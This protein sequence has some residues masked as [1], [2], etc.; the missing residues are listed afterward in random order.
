MIPGVSRSPRTPHTKDV[1]KSRG[2]FAGILLT[3]FSARAASLVL[4]FLLPAPS[5]AR[6]AEHP[7]QLLPAALAGEIGTLAALG[8][9]AAAVSWAS[10]RAGLLV[11]AGGGSFLLVVSQLDLE[12]VR[13]TGEHLNPYW[14]GAYNL[15]AHRRLLK[16]VALG[17]TLALVVAVLL[18]AVPAAVVIA[19]ARRRGPEHV[20][21]TAAAALAALSCAALASESRLAPSRLA[22]RR[23]RPALV[24][25]VSESVAAIGD[26]PSPREVR[27]GIATLHRFLNRPP[28]WF[29]EAGYPVWH[30]AP[31]E[32]A[33][34]A[35]FRA[36]PADGKPD[37]LLVVLESA[38]GW[39]TDV[40]RP[41]AAAR[42]PELHRLWKERG[43]AF[44][45]CIATGYPSIEGRGGIL[46]GIAGHPSGILLY[47]ARDLRVLS[48]GEILARAGYVREL[49]AATSPAFEKMEYWYARWFDAVRY[50]PADTTDEDLARRAVERLEA[51]REAPLFLTLFTIATHPPL[52]RPPGADPKT[53][54]ER[55]LAALGYTDRA[56]GRIFESLRRTPRG[57]NTVVIVVGDHATANPWQAI[58][59]PRL[60]TPNAGENWTTLLV[61]GPGLPAGSVR[62]DLTSQL[63]VGPTLLGLLGLDVSNHF[64]GRDLFEKPAPLP[65]GVFALRFHGL[66]AW[67]GPLLLQARLDD[68]SFAQA[69]RWEPYE[70]EPDPENGD[71]HHGVKQ[72]LSREVQARIEELKTMAR[73]WGAVLD[74]NRVMPP[75]TNGP[76]AAGAREATRAP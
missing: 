11:L 6:V 17:D 1:L 2:A 39:E 41:G 34:Y 55:Y 72:E 13:W 51:P 3:L 20:S 56:L 62:E 5:G 21:W 22:L 31:A 38:R 60:G 9:L 24:G 10:A 63:D 23:A 53:P 64:F 33:S 8:A 7:F 54:R 74:G 25:L 30:P 18:V 67:N 29:P 75:A 69:W 70:S 71:Y 61:A 42:V 48:I 27:T 52:F 4:H 16:E 57:R 66:A 46:L 37:V 36:R 40:R 65:Q 35:G 45:L 14:I 76:S 26:R 50:D 73:A 43:V 28:R 32:E 47:N 49:V 68:P 58:R 15:G 59:L 12:L 19:L 44:P